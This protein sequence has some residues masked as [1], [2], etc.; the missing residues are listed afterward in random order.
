MSM[1]HIRAIRDRL[2]ITQQLLADAIGVSQP[3]V[4]NMENGRA[5]FMHPHAARKL[6][7]FARA[8]GLALTLDMVYG[9]EH[10][11]VADAPQIEAAAIK[12]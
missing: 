6:V 7:T 8:R 3:L 5:D 10:I 2:G 12:P 4:A 9:A 11:P 1:Q